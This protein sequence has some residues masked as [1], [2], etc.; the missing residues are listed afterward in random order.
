MDAPLLSHACAG[1][2]LPRLAPGLPLSHGGDGQEGMIDED[3]RLQIDHQISGL[4]YLMLRCNQ[5]RSPPLCPPPDGWIRYLWLSGLNDVQAHTHE[6]CKDC[7]IIEQHHY[8]PSFHLNL[9]SSFLNAV[10]EDSH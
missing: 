10:I 4:L 2:S 1:R 5:S 8:I 3:V 6:T 7:A 9:N